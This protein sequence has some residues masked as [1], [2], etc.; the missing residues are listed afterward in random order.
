VAK[1]SR[2]ACL[3]LCD[4]D[5]VDG[6][7]ELAK[8]GRELDFP[9]IGGV[10]LSLQY[11]RVTHLLG[12]GVE[13]SR[14]SPP[15]L[16]EIKHWRHERNLKLLGA[17][18]DLGVKLDWGR[19]L[20]LAG[21]GQMGRPHFA[22]AMLEKGYVSEL[23]E[24]FDKYLGKGRPAYVDKVRLAPKEAIGLLRG[25]GF[26]PVLAHP[27]SLGLSPERWRAVIRDWVDWGLAGLEAWHPDQGEAFTAFVRDLA[28]KHRLVATAGSDYHG[29]NKATPITWVRE[30]S[31][32][33]LGV[34]DDLREKL[35]RG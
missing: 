6:L 3:G 28:K 10:E 18:A 33:G 27:I 19:L 4:H 1:R 12:L 8:A 21:G 11:E 5:T 34:V 26:A 31:P 9:V 29:A 2:L 16:G 15:Q 20:A 24:A 22:R 35:K 14:N 13:A 25:K 7:A 17:L 30:R 32:L 23:Q